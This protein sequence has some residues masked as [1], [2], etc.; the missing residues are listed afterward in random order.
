M[1]AAATTTKAEGSKRD[2]IS[3]RT[4]RRLRL[5][6]AKETELQCDFPES[7]DELQVLIDRLLFLANRTRDSDR[8]D[9]LR[10]LGEWQHCDGLSVEEAVEETR[11]PDATVRA[12]LKELEQATP[13]LVSSRVQE[14]G[15]DRGRGRP[16]SLY[17][18]A[19]AA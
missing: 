6:V 11:L 16:T 7:A 18:L 1:S 3:A 5:L 2:V 9:V 13:P 8:A 19:D 12:V 17:R 4:R 10:V 15:D 14:R